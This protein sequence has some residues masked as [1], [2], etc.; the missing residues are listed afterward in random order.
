MIGIWKC[1]K[2]LFVGIG[3]ILVGVC[4]LGLVVVRGWCFVGILY[5][6]WG[7]WVGVGG[8]GCFFL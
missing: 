7:F 3:L 2:W 4:F 5:F 8:V 1:V 6:F